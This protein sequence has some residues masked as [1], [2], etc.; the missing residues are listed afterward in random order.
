MGEHYSDKYHHSSR[1]KYW[2]EVI[3]KEVRRRSVDFD[4]P[5]PKLPIGEIIS[6]STKTRSDRF[7]LVFYPGKS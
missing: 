2:K 3:K 5:M 4:D 1:S 6:I 7:Q